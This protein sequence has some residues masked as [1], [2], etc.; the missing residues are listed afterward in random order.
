MVTT[1]GEESGSVAAPCIISSEP[2]VDEVDESVSKF[3]L[4]SL[5]TLLSSRVLLLRLLVSAASS[6]PK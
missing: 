1:S 5:S 3:E 2:E 6:C 4:E